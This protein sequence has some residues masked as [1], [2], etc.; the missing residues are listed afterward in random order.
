[1][2][3]LR[4]KHST[5]WV[6]MGTLNLIVFLRN[7]VGLPIPTWVYLFVGVL[8]GLL[9]NREELVAY[10]CSMAPFEMCFQYR[11]MVLIGTIFLVIKSHRFRLQ[12]ILP[13]ILILLLEYAHFGPNGIAVTDY[14]RQFV[15]L[16]SLGIVLTQ[17]P[18]DYS[19]GLVIKSFALQTLF[20]CLITLHIG[21]STNGHALAS[22]DR[23]G[24]TY[25]TSKSFSGV[26]NPN[27]GSYISILS[28]IGIMLLYKNNKRKRYLA[29]LPYCIFI[30]LFQSK[31]ALLSLVVLLIFDHLIYG[32]NRALRFIELM[33]I[34]L[35]TAIPIYIIFRPV[36]EGIFNRFLAGD[37]SSGRIDLFNF[38][39]I[40]LDSNEDNILYGIGLYQY[41]ER[42]AEHY[43]PELLA[44]YK[45]VSY[46]GGRLVPVMSHNSV[47]EI[48][49]SWGIP[50]LLAT[51]WLFFIIFKHKQDKKCFY[52]Y[53]PILYVVLFSLQ[54]QFYSSGIVMLSLLYSLTCL[55][56]PENKKEMQERQMHA[57]ES[58]LQK[59]YDPA[60]AR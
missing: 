26:L 2:Q 28:I 12:N 36:F 58:P 17:Q 56:Y 48:V 45:A 16:I 22:G 29:I 49:I 1:M 23:L 7:I 50:G 32:K 54:G 20:A 3:V 31:A 9:C 5:F 51:I 35:L 59:H 18:I 4:N 21:I 43:I 60:S 38:Y 6:L 27:T 37:F 13:I 15:C 46:I 19:D 52:N 41:S 44:E 42:V 25:D 24:S 57:L 10:V 53:M 47:Q 40:F 8:I 11:Y 14:F 34:V 55:E 39:N 33:L 30:I